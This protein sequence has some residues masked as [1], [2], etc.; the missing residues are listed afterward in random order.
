MLLSGH[1]EAV[2]HADDEPEEEV[3]DIEVQVDGGDDVLVGGE[4]DLQREKSDVRCRG[5]EG[6]VSYVVRL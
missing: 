3:D 5:V 6:S 2:E 4:V 1:A